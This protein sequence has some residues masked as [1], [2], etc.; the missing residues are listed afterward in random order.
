MGIKKGE[1]KGGG[2]GGGKETGKN[3]TMT[4]SWTGDLSTGDQRKFHNKNNKIK[5][6][7]KIPKKVTF[8]LNKLVKICGWISW[9]FQAEGSRFDSWWFCFLFL[10]SFFPHLK[11]KFYI[12]FSFIFFFISCFRGGSQINF[13]K[14]YS[15]HSRKNQQIC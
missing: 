12:F 14:I 5:N 1:K 8:S 3:S 9:I 11:E 7:N 4:S 15:G 10:H 2:G 13:N 6:Q